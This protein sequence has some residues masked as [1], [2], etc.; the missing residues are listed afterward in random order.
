MEMLRVQNLTKSFKRLV[1]VSDLSFVIHKGEILGLMGPNGSGKTT[2]IN[3]IT[4]FLQPDSGTIY[5]QDEDITGWGPHK[6][7][8]K[9]IARTFQQARV[10]P[11][12]SIFENVVVSLAKSQGGYL[13]LGIDH[14]RKALDILEFVGVRTKHST[15][16]GQ[17]PQDEL[18]KLEIARAI[19]S[20]P[21]MILL[22]EPVCGLTPEE[23]DSIA[24]VIA[25]LNES[26]ITMI[27]IEHVMRMLMKVSHRLIVVNSG[28]KIC[29]GNPD[30]VRHNPTVIEA[31]FGKG[32]REFANFR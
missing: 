2:V 30:E 1:A 10:F 20:E 32:E 11:N 9:G 15:L 14:K 16:A 6:I 28:M 8:H 21:K 29:E 4:G 23:S 26:G 25:K 19:G 5:W 31:Y 13:S 17:L 22:D 24:R 27:V 7:V 3:L 18:K 12:L